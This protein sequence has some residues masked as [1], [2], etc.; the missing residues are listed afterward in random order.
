MVKHNQPG[1]FSKLGSS[2]KRVPFT[3]AMLFLL[4]LVAWLT[5]TQSG[6]LSAAWLNRLGFAPCD[7]LLLNWERLVTSALVTNGGRV[8]W[9]AIGM[10]ALATGASEWLTSS[11]R[12]GFT[13]WGVHLVTLLTLALTWPIRY[14]GQGF[15]SAAPWLLARD[16]GPSAGYFGSL[17]LVS[18]RLPGRWR[19]LVFGLVWIGL[20][21][22]LITSPLGATGEVVMLS[23][24]LAH[25]LAFPS[26][27]F[28]VFMASNPITFKFF[29]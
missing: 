16:V 12:A 9:E 17:G 23:A 15:Q 22:V 5:D 14:T 7:L 24:N 25:A 18:S 13:F 26:V 6:Q 8:F 11:R 21:V 29:G 2:L 3:L 4:T 27:S 10:I 1:S 28:Q 19:W 20:L